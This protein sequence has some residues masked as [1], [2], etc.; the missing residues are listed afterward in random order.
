MR[1]LSL[2]TI[3]LLLASTA[4]VDESPTEVEPQFASSAATGPAGAATYRVTLS[5]L[6][7][8]QP[9]TPPVAVT[10]RQS[11]SL[12]EVGQPAS[13]GVKEIAENGNL[14]PLI[15]ALQV[16][17]H[18]ADVVVTMGSTGV[19]PV[20]PGETIDFEISTE[21]GAKYFSFVSMLICT[22]DG[23]A[24]VDSE[25]LPG[26]VGE[27]TMVY[28]NAYDAGTE[29][30]TEDFAHIVPPC[31]GLVGVSSD[32]DGTGMSDPALAEGGVVHPHGG[33]QGGDD[34]LPGVH[35]WTDPVAMLTIERI[36]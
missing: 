5:N 4:C 19:P 3:P 17:K 26:A 2:L 32:D 28:V 15:D 36:G 34:L 24:G 20:V 6:T 21:R 8:G 16:E 10:H 18:A 9:F 1:R 13:F 22:N 31:Q 27:S 33:I 11:I 7:S 25:R 29:V 30:N 14:P 23:F 35:G 12:F